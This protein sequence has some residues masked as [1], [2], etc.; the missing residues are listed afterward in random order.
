MVVLFL[1][2][3]GLPSLLALL[4]RGQVRKCHCCKQCIMNVSAGLDHDA[5]LLHLSLRLSLSPVEEVDKVC[6]RH[7]LA[8]ISQA[9]WVLGG[10]WELVCHLLLHAKQLAGSQIQQGIQPCPQHCEYA[11][12]A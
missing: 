5:L 7:P 3:Q 6:S 12:R 10:S 11:L 9:L 2:Q 8:N 4:F 1:I